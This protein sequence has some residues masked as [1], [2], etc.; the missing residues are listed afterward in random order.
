MQL[1]DH[2]INFIFG[3]C[4]FRV[5]LEYQSAKSVILN[6]GSLNLLW[7]YDQFSQAKA[8]NSELK[9]LMEGPLHFQPTYKFDVN[10]NN[11]DTSK[12]SRTPSW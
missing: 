2:D 1:K 8:T 9:C 3:D 6:G 11:W 5:D 12:K 7:E 10:T 4:N